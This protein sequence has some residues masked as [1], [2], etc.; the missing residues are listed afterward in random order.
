MPVRPRLPGFHWL[1]G[2]RNV[3]VRTGVYAGVGLSI[4]FVAWIIIANRV[5]FL[6]RCALE[7]NVAS[8]ALMILFASIPVVRF[9]R[10]PGQLLFSSLIAWTILGVVYR[11]ASA[12]FA[13]LGER[14]SATH[15]FV[16]GAVVYLIITTVSW[17][18]TIV[19]RARASHVSHSN[20]HVS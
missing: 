2:L 12:F 4:V 10:T 11:V 17:L 15:V 3:A 7:R 5:P 19:W 1:D 8:A 18:G 13:G 6:E 20:H 16:L 14:Y 9:V